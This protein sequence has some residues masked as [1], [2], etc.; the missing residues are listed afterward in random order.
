MMLSTYT[1]SETKTIFL[2]FS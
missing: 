2:M 1:G